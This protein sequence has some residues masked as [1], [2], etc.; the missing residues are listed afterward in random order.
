MPA[1]DEQFVLVER[2]PFH[3]PSAPAP[4]ERVIRAYLSRRR[5]EEDLA[6]L[7]EMDPATTYEVQAVEYIDN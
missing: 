6:L 4:I 5:A 7:R 3:Q 2:G 1:A